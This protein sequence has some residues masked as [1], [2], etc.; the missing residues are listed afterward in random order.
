MQRLYKAVKSTAVT[1][2]GDVGQAGSLTQVAT[3]SLTTL[4]HMG[5]AREVGGRGEVF[6]S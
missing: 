2:G 5:E 3:P 6:D 4:A 1:D